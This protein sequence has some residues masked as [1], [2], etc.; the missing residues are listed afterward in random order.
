[1]M[2][3]STTRHLPTVTPWPAPQPNALLEQARALRRA[4]QAGAIQPLLKG[5]NLGLLCEAADDADAALFRHAAIE[6]GAQVAHIRPN[7][8][9]LS[10]PLE[11][12]HTARM[13]GRLYDAIECQGL[14]PAVVR[15]LIDNAGVPVF[16][17][18]ATR[19]HPSSRLAEQLDDDMPCDDP[20]RY[21]VQAM[22][23]GTIA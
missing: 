1:M 20:R 11:V 7:L 3:I 14:S 17:G 4:A 16:D 21:V 23:L 12:Q 10:T 22:L 19:R 9:D 6:L 2:S 5:K 13:L 18:L 15:Q 8:S